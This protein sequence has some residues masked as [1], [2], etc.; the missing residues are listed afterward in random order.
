[1]SPL[2]T[3]QVD[4]SHSSLV[5]APVVSAVL[6][7]ATAAKQPEKYLS[8]HVNNT[9]TK[10]DQPATSEVADWSPCWWYIPAWDG[11]GRG[12]VPPH[13]EWTAPGRTPGHRSSPVCDR[14][15]ESGIAPANQR[16]VSSPPWPFWFTATYYPTHFPIGFDNRGSE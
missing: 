3:T 11:L 14:L 2:T 5:S 4:G 16:T 8:T 13:R 15:P 9:C 7:T 12:R 10:A 1:M 6:W